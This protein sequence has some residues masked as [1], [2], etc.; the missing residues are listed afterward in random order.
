M[1]ADINPGSGGSNPYSL[2]VFN[3]EL[4]FGADDGTN[5]IE[6]WKYDGTN[7]P[8]MV[9]DI[10]STGSSS[11]GGFTV[12]NN[13]LYFQANDGTNGIELWKYDGTSISKY[14]C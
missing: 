13:E 14:G 4:Y 6:L 12:L 3:N 9:A 8:S 11:P 10:S 2:T 7:T 1:V 5:G